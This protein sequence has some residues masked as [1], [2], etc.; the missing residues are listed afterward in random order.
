MVLEE[1]V[2]ASSV[3]HMGLSTMAQGY[4]IVGLEMG[5][6]KGKEME[7]LEIDINIC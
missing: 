3:V 1:V 5:K 4:N 6:D 2:V 7:L